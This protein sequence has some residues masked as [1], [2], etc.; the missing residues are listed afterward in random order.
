MKY[1]CILVILFSLSL[2]AGVR[3]EYDEF[4][5]TNTNLKTLLKNNILTEFIIESVSNQYEIKFS[6]YYESKKVIPSYCIL[7]T[8]SNSIN[9]P[10]S[11]KTDS[12][13][14]T[15]ICT[16]SLPKETFE[17]AILSVY[18]NTGSFVLNF[19]L[20]SFLKT[21]NSTTKYLTKP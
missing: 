14:K 11:I 3:R 13:N 20:V 17:K 18:Y 9:I 6:T 12:H 19:K 5:L 7:K 16:F 2:S 1:T 10:V 8:P 15:S 4:N 21:N